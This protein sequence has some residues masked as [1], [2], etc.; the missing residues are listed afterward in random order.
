MFVVLLLACAPVSVRSEPRAGAVPYDLT[1]SIVGSPEPVGHGDVLSLEITVVNLGAGI[2]DPVLVQT[3]IPDGTTFEAASSTNGIVHH[4]EV[5]STGDVDTT[6]RSLESGDRVVVRLH[7]RVLAEAGTT[8]RALAEANGPDDGAFEANPD[9]N[10]GRT[11][12]PVRVDG[13]S[14]DLELAIAPVGVV[15][16]TGAPFGFDIVLTNLEADT[17]AL[18]VVVRTGT[19]NG[20]TFATAIASGVV[21]PPAPGS[22]GDILIEFDAIEPGHTEVIHVTVNVTTIAGRN[23]DMMASVA[24]SAADPELT[25]N[26]ATA[27]VVVFTSSAFRLDWDS[28]DPGS[29]IALPPPLHL[30]AGEVAAAPA[31]AATGGDRG[32]LLGYN[33]YRAARPDVVPSA[34]NLHQS[35]PGTSTTATALASPGGTFFVVTAVYGDGE[36]AASNEASADVPTARLSSVKV[37]ASKIVANGSGFSATV[38]MFVDGIPFATEAVRK[39]SGARFVQK[40]TLVS[41]ETIG[42]YLASHPVVLITLR[43]ENG[44]VVA[45]RH[46]Q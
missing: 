45:Y 15:A 36:S 46:P 10:S 7:V 11:A 34:G 19:P 44:G 8:I 40:G 21:S 29:G 14:V 38:D 16:G 39:R 35:I 2:A 6:A 12:V 18:G 30:V 1:V 22:R 23:I 24:S 13:S 4:P 17:A 5:G 25:D 31:P 3:S 42:G 27:S 43:N 20:S 33:V 37:T 28:P 41:G 32:A 9:D 26:L